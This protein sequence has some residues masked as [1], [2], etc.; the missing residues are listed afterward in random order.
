MKIILKH[1]LRNIKAKKG[2]ALLIILA[3][4]IAT[5]VFVLNL[6]L[7]NEIILKLQQTLRS[8]YGDIDIEISSVDSFSMNDLEIGNEKISYVGMSSVE[9]DIGDDQ[10]MIYGLDIDNAKSM[11]MIG[12][13]IPELQ[14]NQVVINEKQASDF[15]FKEGQ[16]LELITENGNCEL[17]II[18]IVKK[19]GILSTDVDFPMFIANSETVNNIKNIELGKYEKVY[20]DVVNDDNIS[21]FAKYVSDNN[22]NFI[23]EELVNIDNI[24]DEISSISYMMILICAIATIMIFFVVSSL[25]KLIIAER[26]PVIGTFRSVGANRSK[27]NFILLAENAIYG[28]IGGIFGVILRLFYK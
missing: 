19:F 18:K 27:M 13:D 21:T 16:K 4:I 20:V 14:I 26:M 23:A 2:R 5:S 3:L 12:T 17:E 25:N 7:P 8:M 6:T 15:H 11:R 9:G 10:V 24:R 1:I 28:L 22:E